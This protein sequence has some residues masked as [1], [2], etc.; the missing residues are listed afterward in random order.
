KLDINELTK[1]ILLDA[2]TDI[3]LMKG[4]FGR[5][6]LVLTQNPD[7]FETVFRHEGTWP[8]RKGFELVHYYRTVH[9]KEYFGEVVGLLGSQHQDWGDM[10]SAVNPIIMHPKNVKLYLGSLDRINQQFIQRIKTIRNTETLEMPVDFKNEISAWALE[11]VGMVALNCQLGLIDKTNAK[12]QRYFELLQEFLDFAVAL[13]VNP[14]L[15][16]KFKTPKLRA[17]MKSLDEGLEITDH[18]IKLGMQRI[19]QN[20]EGEKSVLEKLLAI[21]PKYALV[22]ALDMLAAG[23]DTTTS[24]FTAIL[25]ALSKH[26][27][28]QAKLRAEIRSILPQK[29]TP[30][31]EA[32][33]RNLP[34]LRACIKE[35]LRLYPLTLANLRT[36]RQELVLS[37][38]T[39]PAETDVIMMHVNLWA[40]AQHFSQPE[41]F[42]PERWL[43]EQPA[44]AD[45]CPVATKSTHPFAYLPF[46]F[47]PRSCIGRRIAEMEL[48]IGVARLL[49]NF[50]VEF[51]HPMDKPFIAYQ[52]ATPR[53]PLQFKLTDIK[54]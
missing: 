32:S 10:R 36:T 42:I 12:G 50:Q 49:R 46:G 27:E 2:N 22:M 48:E 8:Y 7:D 1:S 4:M 14:S 13:E 51:N 11:S 6:S 19:K 15:W 34:Y 5:S 54:D 47:G 31:T 40:D 20:S 9:R 3:L 17:A 41:Q 44:T 16:R 18:F 25:L 35:S 21:N 23:V 33:M 45:G 52:L 29:D 37:G 28:Q 38:Y 53:I 43:R 39:V 24:S 26:P 30:F